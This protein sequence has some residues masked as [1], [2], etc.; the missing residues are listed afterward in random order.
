MHRSHLISAAVAA[1]VLLAPLAA[2]AGPVFV[3]GAGE[4]TTFSLTDAGVT[5]TFTSP[6]PSTQFVTTPGFGGF[7]GYILYDTGVAPNANIPLDIGFSSAISSLSFYYMTDGTGTITMD[8]YNAGSLVASVTQ[9][10]VVP[11]GQRYPQGL[12]S[13]SGSSFDSVVFTSTASAFALANGDSN[14]GI[15]PAVPEPASLAVLAVGVIGLL[16]AHRRQARV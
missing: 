10:G 16:G 14:P 4:A 7:T 1:L 2:E 6:T 13:F 11:S 3:F 5:A 8:A 9:S 12:I 15:G